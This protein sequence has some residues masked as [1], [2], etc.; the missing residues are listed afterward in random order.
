PAL[1]QVPDPAHHLAGHAVGHLD[2]A[3]D[4]AARLVPAAAEVHIA[5]GAPST[6][7]VPGSA[8][9]PA[10]CRLAT[11]ARQAWSSTSSGCSPSNRALPAASMR[12]SS[13]MSPA[14]TWDGG[15]PRTLS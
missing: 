14:G 2:A 4:V 13:R 1:G 12:D 7:L 6:P 15:W 11:I 5:H 3:L 8:S 9:A 10:G